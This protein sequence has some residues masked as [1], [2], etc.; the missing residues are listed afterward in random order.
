MENRV[1]LFRVLHKP[2]RIRRHCGHVNGLSPL[3]L[4]RN[5]LLVITSHVVAAVW[6]S[7][8]ETLAKSLSKHRLN[9]ATALVSELWTR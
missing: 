4:K 1:S 7:L 9:P 3:T 6:V 5:P 8:W 2:I